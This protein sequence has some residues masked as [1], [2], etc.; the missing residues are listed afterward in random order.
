MILRFPIDPTPHRV[1]D[2]DCENYAQILWPTKLEFGDGSIY[3]EPKPNPCPLGD[4]GEA[5]K[6]TVRGHLVQYV[7]TSI[8]VAGGPQVAAPELPW[9]WVV[10]LTQVQE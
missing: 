5:L 6:F 9:E 4:V 10:T 1:C 2:P 7:I 8:Q 3:W